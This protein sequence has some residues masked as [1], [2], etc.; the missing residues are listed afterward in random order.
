MTREEMLTFVRGLCREHPTL[1]KP[2]AE[3]E[4]IVNKYYDCHEAGQNL[5]MEEN[6]VPTGSGE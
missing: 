6:G 2:I 4:Q 1:M 5:L 3:V